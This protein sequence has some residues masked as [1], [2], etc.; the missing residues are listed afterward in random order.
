MLRESTIDTLSSVSA[1]TFAA[2]WADPGHALLDIRPTAAY[3]GWPLAGEMRGGHVPGAKHLPFEWT[4]Y[5]DWVEVVEEKQLSPDRPVTIYGYDAD[6]AEAMAGKLSRLGFDDLWIY[7]GFVDDWA[8]NPRRPV[9]RLKRYK[10]LV[11]PDWLHGL[12]HGD[13]E[14]TNGTNTVICHAHFDHRADYEEGHIPGAIPLNTNWLESPETWNRRS[15][16]ELEDA[17]CRLGIQRDTTVVLYGRF[18]HPTYEQEHPAQSAGHL[19]AMRCAAILL[20]AGVQDVRILNGGLNTWTA[21][22]YDLSTEDVAPASVDST[23]LDVPEHPEYMLDLDGAEAL[24]AADDGELVSVRSWS[25]FI[26]ERSGYHYIEQTGR[27]PGAVFGNCG[28]D[29][30]HMENYRNFDYTT[31][32]FEEVARKWGEAAIVPSK[33]IGFYCGTGWRGSEAFMNAYLMGW[34]RI[35]VYDGGWFEWSNAG[36]PSETGPPTDDTSDVDPRM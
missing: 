14:D 19:G 6:E 9:S 29:A 16:A 32:A 22:G 2:H 17:L 21:A 13:A 26:G 11:P 1:K 30:Y 8:A 15:P 28:S 4:Q 20:Y 25:E 24:L 35:S 33:H 10:Q 18:S 12:L 23:G 34:P 31:R 27:I 36:R 3:N 5:M 7:D